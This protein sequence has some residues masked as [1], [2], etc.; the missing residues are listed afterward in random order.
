MQEDFCY[1]I[2]GGPMRGTY[3]SVVCETGDARGKRPVRRGHSASAAGIGRPPFSKKKRNGFSFLS[4]RGAYARRGIL[5]CCVQIRCLPGRADSPR[6][7]CRFPLRHKAAG[8]SLTMTQPSETD[9]GGLQAF[10][11]ESAER[12]S[13]REKHPPA[14]ARPTGGCCF[15]TT[16]F[17]PVR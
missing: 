12:K 11:R 4:P 10:L 17:L 16:D 5:I 8:N 15:F 14:G 6:S 3:R 7:P 9:P 2:P 1:A 13:E